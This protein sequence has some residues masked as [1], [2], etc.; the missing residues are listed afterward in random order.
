MRGHEAQV[1][2]VALSPDGRRLASGSSDET[3]RLWDVETG[4]EVFCLRGHTGSLSAIMFSPDGQLIASGSFDETILL[5]D[6]HAGSLV[7]RMR[8]H[9]GVILGLAFAPD[10]RQI[11]SGSGDGTVRLWSVETGEQVL[12][13]RG[14]E[15]W[16]RCVA[17]SSDGK[18]VA[19]GSSD[20][21]VRLW[22][23]QRQEQKRCIR[24]D[25]VTK[26]SATILTLQFAADNRCLHVASTEGIIHAWDLS[27][28]IELRR[29]LPVGAGLSCVSLSPM[30]GQAAIGRRD[31]V[32]LLGT[33]DGEGVSVE[34]RGHE[35]PVL[36]TAFSADG[37]LMASGGAER[38]VRVWD[39][40]AE[41]SSVLENHADHICCI[42]FS[43]DGVQAAS[44]ADDG[45]L[46]IWKVTTG[47][48]RL[49]LAAHEPGATFGG[50]QTTGGY[51]G[52][53]RMGGIRAIA[54]SADAHWLTTSGSN[55][56]LVRVWDTRTGAEVACLR[57]HEQ[58]INAMAFSHTGRWLA[59]AGWDH[60][61]RIWDTSTWQETTLLGKHTDSVEDVA[62]S[63]DDRL[64]VSGS[65]DLTVRVWTLNGDELLCLRGHLRAVVRV[66][67]TPDQRVVLSTSEDGTIRA[68][69]ANGQCVGVE[70]LTFMRNQ[71]L[72]EI[73]YNIPGGPWY[74]E[75]H[76][77]RHVIRSKR[78]RRAVGWFSAG[79][80]E[81]PIPHPDGR[82]WASPGGRHLYLYTLEG[83]ADQLDP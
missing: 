47:V 27:S 8:G 48:P 14:H 67:F 26:P 28:G 56:H 77:W 81:L 82:T 79:V 23:I 50:S 21:T 24:H 31:G 18:T 40:R 11:V 7:H 80:P 36:C 6:V 9:K 78:T 34:F 74:T 5:W 4:Q 66:A 12:C 37:R 42:V 71:I 72:G 32:V 15:N 60:T 46:W 3:L 33:V 62:F 38:T 63:P 58:T 51:A 2:S 17:F 75:I 61:V 19:S 16:V 1:L 49:R 68:W 76:D 39:P 30:G 44:G 35:G 45:S 43:E 53:S 20:A 70:P 55:D 10:G 64:V 54:F 65:S 73:R 83:A 22:D 59:C 29:T 25:E 13:L 52:G 57:G 69:D 41:K